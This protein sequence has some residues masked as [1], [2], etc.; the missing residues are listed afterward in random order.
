MTI[1]AV[2]FQVNQKSLSELFS[3]LKDLYNVD[4]QDKKTTL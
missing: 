4:T 1:E 2:D 3:G